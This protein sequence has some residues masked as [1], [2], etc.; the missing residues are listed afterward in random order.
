MKVLVTGAN[1]FL[2]AW[3]TKALV[4]EGHEVSALVRKTSDL[5]DLQGV[6]LRLIEGDVTQPESLDLAF[7]KQD[8]IFHLAGLVAY[9]KSQ[10]A[11]MEKINVDGTRHVIEACRRRDIRRLVHMSSVTAIGAGF[12]PDEILN[13]NSPFNLAHLNMG[14]FETKRAAEELVR[15]AV[16]R[17]ELDA[18]ILNP[19]TIYG[20][21][22]AKKGS[23]KIQ[24]K[25]A[26][27]EFPYYT[28]GGVNVIAVQDVVE[29]VLQAW[30]KGRSGERYILSGQNLYI[31]ELF[32]FIAEAAGE[33]PP[34]IPLPNW[35][36][37]L[38]GMT[39][40]I[41][42]KFGATSS[43]SLENA[44]VSTMYHWFDNSKARRE[45]GLIPQPAKEAIAASVSWMQ[46]Q[47]LLSK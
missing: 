26:R 38:A 33:P 46:E 1:G 41:R 32:R 6:P 20:P 29:G 21:A 9:R 4:E 42:E 27:G 3:L 35:L 13:E 30:K 47:G 10:R 23:R 43:L 19:S 17:N 28:Q 45:L 11:L 31:R 15:E 22:D 34:S 39:G 16:W 8:S 18:V 12:S 37:Y 25:V 7:E 36:V 44:R 24:I 2:G 5:S 40:E 14:Y